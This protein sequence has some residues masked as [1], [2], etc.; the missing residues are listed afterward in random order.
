MSLKAPFCLRGRELLRAGTESSF[1]TDLGDEAALWWV[2][3]VF[4]L[5]CGGGKKSATMKKVV[6][7]NGA[8]T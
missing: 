2:L 4:T 5:R 1:T 6:D 7:A 3:R 8:A